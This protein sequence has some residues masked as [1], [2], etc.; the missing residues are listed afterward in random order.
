M[1]LCTETNKNLC[2]LQSKSIT[3]KSINEYRQWV[4]YDFLLQNFTI[5]VA[6]RNSSI[7]RVLCTQGSYYIDQPWQQF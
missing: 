7:A 6:Y 3:V 1:F 5:I 2:Y 4:K